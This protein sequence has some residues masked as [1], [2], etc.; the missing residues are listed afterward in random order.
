[1]SKNPHVFIVGCP[2]SGTTLLQRMLDNHPDLAVA[3]DTHFIPRV[4]AKEGESNPPL[5]PDLVRR[6]QAYRRFSRLGLTDDE[7]SAAAERAES[8]ATFVQHLYDAF[9]SRNGKQLAGD[10][11]PDYGQHI[12]RLLALFPEAKFVHIVRDGRDVALSTIDWATPAKGP[13]R[14]TL[15]PASPMAAAAL[16]W[17]WQVE[18]AIEARSRFG[19]DRVFETR[20]EDLVAAPEFELDRI[21]RFLGLPFDDA[22]LKYHEGREKSTANRSPKSAWLRPT[23]GLRDWRTEME[24]HDLALF[25]ELAGDLLGSL[26]YETY[27]EKESLLV[28]EEADLGWNWWQ[29]CDGKPRTMRKSINHALTHN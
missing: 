16:W 21:A 29:A 2:R 12:P 19:P 22:M 6:V 8:Y 3:N 1:M 23:L 18:P 26:G 7:V 15:W 20:Y 10:K 9:A 25:E 5:T 14:W 4:I 17:R 13:G 28:A 27:A 11:T 24:P